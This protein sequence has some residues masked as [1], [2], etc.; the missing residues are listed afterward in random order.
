M[1]GIALVP[2]VQSP[3]VKI[4]ENKNVWNY[5]QPSDISRTLVDNKLV[6]QSDVIG[7]QPV[8]AA[9]S[10]FSTS[11]LA[12]MDWAKTIAKR[13]EKHLSFGIWCD[14]Y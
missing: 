2:P 12:S 6:D 9:I 13:E 3:S 14:V 10:S 5:S 4:F 1:G 7:A 8:G 11:H